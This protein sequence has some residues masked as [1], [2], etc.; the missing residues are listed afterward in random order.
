MRS[1]DGACARCSSRLITARCVFVARCRIRTTAVC[2]RAPPNANAAPPLATVWAIQDRSS[3]LSSRKKIGYGRHANVAIVFLYFRPRTVTNP[4]QW[5]VELTIVISEDRSHSLPHPLFPNINLHI[6]QQD[7]P[8]S[9]NHEPDCWHAH[10]T[11]GNRDVQ[12]RDVLEHI[13]RQL[14][15]VCQQ[16]WI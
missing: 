13:G 4:D 6:L 14:S 3:K 2:R 5:S 16:H 10:R 7:R 15:V 8:T 11:R 12:V 1:V 9:R